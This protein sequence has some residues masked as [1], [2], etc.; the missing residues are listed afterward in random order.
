[1]TLA[2]VV[3]SMVEDEALMSGCY[4]IRTCRFALC[5]AFCSY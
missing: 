1:M 3:G 4:G 5:S 2:E